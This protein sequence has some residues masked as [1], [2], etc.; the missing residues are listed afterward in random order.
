MTLLTE[1]EFYNYSY[2]PPRWWGHNE[3]AE[4]IHKEDLCTHCE[5]YGEVDFGQFHSGTACTHCEGTGLS[6]EEKRVYLQTYRKAAS[7]VKIGLPLSVLED[8]IEAIES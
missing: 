3:W 1:K 7:L 5:G 4:S 8:I 6:N 2:Y